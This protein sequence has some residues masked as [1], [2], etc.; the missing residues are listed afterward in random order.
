[1]LESMEISVDVLSIVAE[2]ST[3]IALS[4]QIPSSD[5][6]GKRRYVGDKALEYRLIVRH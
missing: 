6:F 3:V 1:M 2:E 4:F 5:M